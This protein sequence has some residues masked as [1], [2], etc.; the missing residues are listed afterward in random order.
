MRNWNSAPC[1]I[2]WLFSVYNGWWTKCDDNAA[3]PLIPNEE[4]APN[5]L[6]ENLLSF[7]SIIFIPSST[8]L[9]SLGVA[10]DIGVVILLLHGRISF[11]LHST[12]HHDTP[13]H[14]PFISPKTVRDVTNQKMSDFAEQI[15][16]VVD[17]ELEDVEK[18][19]IRPLQVW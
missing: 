8:G 17:K 14:F 16:R 15:S 3:S 7:V 4:T 5:C 18:H 13:D 11:I 2:I 6:P 12:T 19:C 9:L 10:K 1:I